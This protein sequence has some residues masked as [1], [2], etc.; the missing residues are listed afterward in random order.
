M[1]VWHTVIERAGLRPYELPLRRTW[2]S[3]R[4]SLSRRCGWLVWV[5][6]D[7]LTG[8][9]DCAPLPSAGTETHE[10]AGALLERLIPG[11]PG[12]TPETLQATLEADNIRAATPAAC[13]ALDCA[14]ADLA[15]RRQGVSLRHWL[16]P[17][18][19]GRLEVNAMLGTLG[20]VDRQDLVSGQAKG[21]RVVKLKVGVATPQSE[22][23]ALL[24]LVRP[25]T[26][27]AHLRLR[28][29]ANGAWSLDQARWFIERL[30]QNRLPIESLEEPLAEPDPERLAELQAH[31]SFPLALDESLSTQLA[32][33]DPAQL[34]VRRLVLKPA[35][36]GGLR[37]TL[38]LARRAQEAGIESVVTSLIES[39]AGLWPTVQLAAAIASP[40][41]QGL[42]TADW[43]ADDLGQ[44]PRPRAGWIRLPDGPG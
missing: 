8:Y 9:G 43:L 39:A 27:G 3:A 23:E 15:S 19:V 4:G 42:A 36:L 41:A 12:Q 32:T 38:A 33:L 44:A 26:V 25:P 20:Q 17:A 22:L 29:D 21:F 1:A 24:A 13:F 2:Y 37:R 11:L 18:A 28:L 34:G 31:A 30:I 40:L 6:A 16:T 10:A 14:L 7:G 5:Q 35:V